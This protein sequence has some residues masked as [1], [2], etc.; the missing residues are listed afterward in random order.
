MKYA[1]RDA[2]LKYENLAKIC[3][4]LACEMRRKWFSTK[5]MPIREKLSCGL[6][7]LLQFGVSVIVAMTRLFL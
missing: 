6:S 3:Y 7:T 5:E 1:M 2:F 4:L